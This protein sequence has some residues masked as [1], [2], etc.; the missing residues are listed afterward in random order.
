[1]LISED[2]IIACPKILNT[3]GT[4]NMTPHATPGLNTNADAEDFNFMENSVAALIRLMTQPRQTWR[5]CRSSTPRFVDLS[6][7]TIGVR[8]EKVKFNTENLNY[9]QKSQSRFILDY[10]MPFGLC[11]GFIIT[12]Q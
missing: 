12:F 10:L 8:S 5:F 4:L 3:V 9:T 11:P 2:F 6:V 7:F 1:M